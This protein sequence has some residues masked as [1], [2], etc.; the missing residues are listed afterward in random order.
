MRL[1]PILGAAITLLMKQSSTKAATYPELNAVG[2]RW[3]DRGKQPK[4]HLPFSIAVLYGKPTSVHASF[5]QSKRGLN[6]IETAH[7]EIILR[8]EFSI[9]S[10]GTGTAT[11]NGG[12]QKESGRRSDHHHFYVSVHYKCMKQVR[13][14]SSPVKQFCDV[15]SPRFCLPFVE[16]RRCIC[17]LG[18]HFQNQ[19]R[20]TGT[21]A[22]LIRCR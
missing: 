14:F 6:L 11:L 1:F 18:T 20:E 22:I 9:S 3:M 12:V 5:K 17:D 2:G 4:H 13:L 15:R 10:R 16:S 7:Q 8:R 21:H 19:N